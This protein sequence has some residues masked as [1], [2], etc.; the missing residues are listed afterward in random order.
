L[1]AGSE[2]RLVILGEPGYGKTVAALTLIA[3][4]DAHDEPG[5]SVAEVFSLAD[6][7]AWQGQHPGAR[8]GDWLAE[9]LTLSYPSDLPLQVAGQLVTAGLVLLLSDTLGGGG[10]GV[11]RHRGW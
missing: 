10:R 8:L 2:G 5:A 6:W 7:F 4:I 3:H 1:S 11:E 9:Q